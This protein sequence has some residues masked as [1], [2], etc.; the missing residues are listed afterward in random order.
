MESAFA[1]FWERLAEVKRR[2]CEAN[3]LQK[4]IFIINNYVMSKKNGYRPAFTKENAVEMGR[5]GAYAS[6]EAKR[7]KR[8]LRIIAEAM[9]DAKTRATLPDGT[10]ENL[11]F[12][13]ALVLSQYMK[14]IDERDTRAARF[15][16]ELLGELKCTIETETGSG[17]IINVRNQQEADAIEDII[18]RPQD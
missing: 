3:D 15:I 9:A 17:I 18:N 7:R 16:A 1:A 6:A 5:R 12:D 2:A 11:N 8:T 4:G 10:E 14:A 13:E